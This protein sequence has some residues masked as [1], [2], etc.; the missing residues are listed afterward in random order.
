M[1]K[2]EQLI[3]FI[4]NEQEDKAREL[5]HQIVVEK[6]REIY[7]SLIDES[8][9]EEIG[10]NQV[11]RLA[12]EVMNDEEQM[13]SEDEFAD[14]EPTDDDGMEQPVAHDEFTVDGDMDHGDG[15]G[16]VEDRVMDLE[17]AL[18]ELKAE[19]D[20]LMGDEQNEPE[21]HDI[22]DDP[23]FGA[24]AGGDEDE[25][26]GEEAAMFE[27]ADDEEDDEEEEDGKKKD[28]VVDESRRRT[29]RG[30][31]MTEAEWIRE[32]VEKI[33][34]YPGE[35]SSPSGKMAGTGNKS[36]KQGE[37]NTKSVVAGKNDM[38]GTTKNIVGKQGA[39]NVDP[40]GKQIE[41]PNNEYSK[42]KGQL[43]D[44]GK[45]KNAPGGNAGK[46][47]YKTQEG[48]Y[49]KEHEKEGKLAGA[50]GRRPINAKSPM[51]HIGK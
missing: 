10:G 51:K 29:N 18:D 15:E 26:G 36:E 16:S 11:E 27:E 5:F 4:I 6:S 40:D 9:L 23:E 8:D 38:G 13:E 46:S 35:Q 44:A 39:T 32:Y 12:H 34:E 25:E 48:E 50:D 14:E 28:K 41:Q 20:A 42:G 22:I 43:K 7:E 1:S 37:K 3:E 2:Y 21:H 45:F 24:M 33:G 49:S 31:K 19:F 30:R 47:A 17:D